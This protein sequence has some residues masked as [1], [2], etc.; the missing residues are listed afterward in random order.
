MTDIGPP[1]P[2]WD[3][4]TEQWVETPAVVEVYPGDP[5]PSTAP[6]VVDLAELA[7]AAEA[8]DSMSPTSGSRRGVLHIVAAL[9]PPSQEDP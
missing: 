7:A 8:V 3:P 4:D 1:P 5:A 6:I 9:T 2:T